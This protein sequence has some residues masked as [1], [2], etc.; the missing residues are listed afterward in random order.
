MSVLNN[1]T[2]TKQKGI[3]SCWICAANQVLNYLRDNG[4]DPKAPIYQESPGAHMGNAVNLLMDLYKITFNTDEFVIPTINEIESEMALGNPLVS[5]VG[6]IVTTPRTKA[7][8]HFQGGHWVVIVGADVSANTITVSD[9]DTGT[10]N[11]V[12]YDA[13]YNPAAGQYFQN[14]SYITI[15]DIIAEVAKR[16]PAP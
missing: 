13:F 11:T 16:D 4:F 2:S 6:A 10:L 14:T 12:P 3:N 8:L 9:P 7:I 5:C 15:S 1:F